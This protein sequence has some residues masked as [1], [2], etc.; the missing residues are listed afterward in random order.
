M[1]TPAT[2]ILDLPWPHVRRFGNWHGLRAARQVI[3]P[4]RNAG[5]HGSSSRAGWHALPDQLDVP[6]ECFK[7][8][9]AAGAAEPELLTPLPLRRSPASLAG[10]SCQRRSARRVRE[11]R[12]PIQRPGAWLGRSPSRRPPAPQPGRR[13]DLIWLRG[14]VPK[15]GDDTGLNTTWADVHARVLRRKRRTKSTLVAQDVF[16]PP[17]SIPS[18]GGNI[19]FTSI[20]ATTTWPVGARGVWV[21]PWRQFARVARCVSGAGLSSA[22][23]ATVGGCA[24]TGR[25]VK[26]AWAG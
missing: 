16:A 26:V 3:R 17:L 22:V 23:I 1:M 19:A 15:R 4:L 6:R 24:G 13:S 5:K 11:E 9:N 10:K 20:V 7:E 18:F 14:P 25:R 8:R 2:A 21:S 12:P